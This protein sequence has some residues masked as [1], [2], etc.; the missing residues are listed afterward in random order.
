MDVRWGAVLAGFMA[1]YVI[2]AIIQL[3][4]NVQ[5]DFLF[6]VDPSRPDHLLYLSLFA[7]STGIGG[8]V[9]ARIARMQGP[10]HG[11]LVGVVGVLLAQVSIMAS[12]MIPARPLV[13]NSAIG[14]LLGA[15][16]GV[17]AMQR[18]SKRT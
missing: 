8:F 12:G 16:G 6:T 15:L 3:L 9:A 10:L 13:I 14:C 2:S 4:A 11:F 5:E 17:L 18:V 7:L 1:D